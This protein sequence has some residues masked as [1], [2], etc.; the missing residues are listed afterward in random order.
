M[1]YLKTLDYI[2]FVLFMIGG[3][4]GAIKGF[5]EEVSSKF[6]YVAGFILALMFTHVLSPVFS[7]K[8]GLPGWVAAWASYFLIFMAGYLLMKGFG[9]IISNITESANLTVVD[10]LLGFAL[11]LVEAFVLLA[12]FEYIMGFQNLF[13]LQHLFEESLFSSRLIMPF[14]EACASTIKSFI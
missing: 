13:N 2:L 4:W 3:I 8:L 5:M 6:G 14:A 12:A 1:Q 9:G 10:H 7:E 11:G